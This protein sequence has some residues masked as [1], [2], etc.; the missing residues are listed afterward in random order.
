MLRYKTYSGVWEDTILWFHSNL[1]S[2]ITGVETLDVPEEMIIRE[3]DE[4]YLQDRLVG[5]GGKTVLLSPRA[6]YVLWK[7][8][9]EE[10]AYID[11]LKEKLDMLDEPNASNLAS[12]IAKKEDSLYARA[13][14]FFNASEKSLDNGVPPAKIDD[15]MMIEVQQTALPALAAVLQ[16]VTILGI[17][18]IITVG[19]VFAVSKIV[20]IF[21]SKDE[22]KL[23]AATIQSLI[24]SGHFD[25]IKDVFS[26]EE[27]EKGFPWGWLI[28]A[29]AGIAGAALLINW[30][31]EQS[32]GW[33]KKEAK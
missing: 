8:M 31:S 10:K 16:V 26:A 15:W 27:R 25:L 28:G 11:N 5:L 1:P 20:D 22:M 6:Q 4:A 29:G 14:M 30:L 9:R 23:K 32:K 33:F 13:D 18:I 3:T 7:T 24:D 12:W 17:A 2:W 19:V 21:K